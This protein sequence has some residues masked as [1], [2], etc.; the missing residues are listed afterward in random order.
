MGA[1]TTAAL[2]PAPSHVTSHPRRPVTMRTTPRTTTARALTLLAPALCAACGAETAL[3]GASLSAGASAAESSV[4]FH[5]NSALATFE[6]ARFDDVLPAV[7]HT[8]ALLNLES[9]NENRAP[10]RTWLYYRYHPNQKLEVTVRRRSET[11]TSV[12]LKVRRPG[13]RAM[14]TLLV[15]HLAETLQEREAYVD[16]SWLP[17]DTPSHAH[18]PMRTPH[19]TSDAQTREER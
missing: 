12:Y 10:E 17:S 9:L 5:S 1:S 2:P 13:E 14:A 15:K 4:S 19:R 7:E 16:R 3:I 8:A 18:D 11:V 6:L